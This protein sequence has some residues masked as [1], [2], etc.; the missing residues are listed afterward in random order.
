[1][2][3]VLVIIF[4]IASG[5]A[6]LLWTRFFTRINKGKFTPEKFR[7]NKIN[8]YTDFGTFTISGQERQ[9]YWRTPKEKT[10]S[11]NFENIKGITYKEKK[12]AILTEYFFT[13][14]N[15]T[16]FLPRYGEK[17]TSYLITLVLSQEIPTEDKSKKYALD[18]DQKIPLF[19]AQQYEIRDRIPI[20]PT[21][22]KALSLYHDAGAYSR[23]VLYEILRLFEQAGKKM[24]LLIENK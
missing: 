23:R 16:D 11:C 14:L 2:G 5:V 13:D 7:A 9:L 21:V 6:L 12:G 4:L 18:D 10:Y 17:T 15:I 19:I 20:L 3:T 1:M 24:G 8:I 22:L